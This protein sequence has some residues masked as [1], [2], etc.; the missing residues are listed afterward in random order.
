MLTGP[1]LRVEACW[2]SFSRAIRGV[3][4]FVLAIL[5]ESHGGHWTHF[6]QFAPPKSL[7]QSHLQHGLRV[8]HHR[9]EVLWV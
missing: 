8:R 6:H 7:C 2:V 4:G 1:E 9:V 5:S 3:P